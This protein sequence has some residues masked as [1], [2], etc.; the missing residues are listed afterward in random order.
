[1]QKYPG[2]QMN[3]LSY[4]GIICAIPTTWR[5]MLR[6]RN[7]GEAQTRHEQIQCTIGGKMIPLIMLR[8]RHVYKCYIEYQ[9]PTAEQRWEREGYHVNWSKV[10]EGPYKCTKSTRLQSLHYR[11]VHR[12]IPTAKFLHVR[13]VKE[14]P[15]CPKCEV[16]EDLTHF[17]FECQDVKPLWNAILTR[18]KQTFR[19]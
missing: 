10:Y 16:E 3:P 7:S 15:M 11:I 4:Q 13:R 12:F 19:L 8:S 2:G 9:K 6:N 17:I 5:R 1:M 14:S 18:L